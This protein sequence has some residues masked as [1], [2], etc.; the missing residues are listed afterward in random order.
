MKKE[1]KHI[2][3]QAAEFYY[4]YLNEP[5]EVPASI[6][7]HIEQ[8]FDCREELDRLKG[9]L[10]HPEPAGQSVRSD[11]LRCQVPLYEQWVGCRKV[12][13]FLPLLAAEE[14]LP[15][16]PTPAAAHLAHCPLCRQDL[17]ALKKL[18]LTAEQALAAARVLSGDKSI[19]VSVA[20]AWAEGLKAME[21][22]EDSDVL[23]KLSRNPDGIFQIAVAQRA[24]RPQQAAA[25]RRRPFGWLRYAAAAVLL[26][27]VYLLWQVRPARGLDI[28]EVYQLLE[29][30]VNAAITSYPQ[31]N[32]NLII[33]SRVL[34]EQ[35][36]LQEI[37]ISNS[38]GV[39]LFIGENYSV[40]WDLNRN[41]KCIKTPAGIE[42]VPITQPVKRFE[43]PW[44]LLPFRCPSELPDKYKWRMVRPEE[45]TGPNV[46]VYDL[47][48]TDY[49][50]LGRPIERRWRGYLD[51]R[52][53]LLLQVDRW[54]RSENHP[55]QKVSTTLIR[56]PQ[57]ADVLS[58]I[59]AEG[60]DYRPAVQK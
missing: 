56:Y 26:I 17:T 6:R 57:D 14:L 30:P 33:A 25:V 10:E 43:I 9:I 36:P 44:G 35:P 16:V 47:T 49:S 27:S 34:E 4:D 24:A 1:S 58:R 15:S 52:T 46:Q 11:L 45:P 5:S 2:C 7:E 40:L 50:A 19:C 12:R 41:H 29:Q 51:T 53:K 3:R 21:H 55:F 42:Q 18:T 48:W 8:C 22:R 54:E 13:P 28:S 31:E 23:T 60:F 39:Y 59:A 32:Q 20:G 37:W 38:L